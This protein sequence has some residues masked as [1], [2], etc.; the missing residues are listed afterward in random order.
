MKYCEEC[1]AELEDGAEFCDECGAKQSTMQTANPISQKE[2]TQK[3]KPSVQKSRKSLLIIIMAVVVLA[4]LAAVVIL[5]MSN[6]EI[7]EDRQLTTEKDVVTNEAV[8]Q[9]TEEAIQES[10]IEAT[11]VPTEQPTIVS[12]KPPTPEPTETETEQPTTEP[13]SE[14]THVEEVDYSYL[15]PSWYSG[16]SGGWEIA[17]ISVSGNQISFEVSYFDEEYYV[18]YYTDLI[19]GT[20]ENGTVR[21]YG[22]VFAPGI[23]LDGEI[24]FPSTAAGTAYFNYRI[25]NGTQVEIDTVQLWNSSQYAG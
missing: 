1:G 8:A 11:S 13:T 20:I 12:T 25:E 2:S 10:D 9:A 19:A 4:V 14:A 3:E 18:T 24:D 17:I 21:F 16:T 22:E 6:Q 5:V 7:S 23:S 15:Q